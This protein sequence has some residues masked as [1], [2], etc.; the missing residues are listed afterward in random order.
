MSSTPWTDPQRNAIYARGGTL[1]VSA[2]AGSGKTAVLVE[3]VV[4]L[5]CDADNP[6]DVNRL[7][8]VTFSNAAANE[9]KQRV[10]LRLSQEIAKDPNNNYLQKQ[11]A[12]LGSASIST[13]HAF[14]LD[15]I[16]Q[17]FQNL[18]ISPDFMLLDE[19]ELDLLKNECVA[20]TLEYFY[21]SPEQGE[22]FT[23]LVEL[24]SSGRDDQRLKDTIF[25]IYDFA[26]SHPFYE[27]WL[28]KKLAMYN[29]TLAPKDTPWGQSILQHATEAL[30]YSKEQMEYALELID[31]DEKLI[32]GYQPMFLQDVRQLDALLEDC[33]Q[34]QWN[35]VVEQSRNF[36]FDRLGSVRGDCPDKDTVRGIRDK[37]KKMIGDLSSRYFNATEQEFQL[38]IV[39]LKPKITLLFDV[40][41]AFGNKLDEEKRIRKKLDFSDLEHLTIELLRDKNGEISP[42]AKEISSQFDYI[43]VDE[44]QDTN[45]VQDLIFTSISRNENNLFMVGDVKQSIYSFRM[46]MPEIFLEKKQE[47]SAFDGADF[48]ATIILDTNFRSRKEVTDSVNFI[49]SHSM[50]PEI[51]E[52]SYDKSETLKPGAAYLEQEG[53]EPEFLLYNAENYE[54]ELDYTQLEAVEIAKKIRSMLHEG[55]QVQERVGGQLTFRPARPSDFCILLRTHRN[56]AKHYIDALQQAGVPAWAESSGGFLQAREVAAVVSLLRVLDNPLLD[57]ELAAV[58]LSPLFHFTSDELAEIRLLGKGQRGSSLYL[59]LQL[60]GEQGNDKASAMLE[61]LSHFRRFAVSHSADRLLMEI[62]SKT[63]FLELVRVMPMGQS[64]HA[65]LLLLIE[66]AAH[67]HEMGYKGLGG[68]VSLLERVE[69][70]GGD[71]EPANILGDSANVVRVMS[72][73]RSKGLEFPIVIMADAAKEFN[74][75]DLRDIT[76]LHSEFGFACVRRDPET[77]AQYRTVPMGAVQLEMQ[78]TLLSE[79]MRVLYVALTRAREK[80]I[81][82][83]TIRRNF[84][85]TLENLAEPLTKTGT[86]SPFRINSARSYSDWIL[87]ALFHHPSAGEL[88]EIVGVEDLAITP[89]DTQWRITV[90]EADGILPVEDLPAVERSAQP[91]PAVVAFLEEKAAYVYPHLAQTKLPTK[92]AISEVATG[93]SAA[94]YHFTRRPRFLSETGLTPAERGTA[95]HTFMQFAN[96]QQARDNVERE[97]QRMEQQEF[98]SALEAQSLSRERISHFFHSALAD[99]IFDSDAVHRELR[100]MAEFGKRELSQ[101]YPDLDEESKI[102]LQGVADCVFI[103]NGNAIIVDYK[104]DRLATLEELS[105]RY[106]QQLALYREILADSLECPVTETIL[107]SFHLSDWV[108]TAKRFP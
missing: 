38:D 98:L 24:L 20:E 39:D 51:G 63:D 9:M 21:A 27:E 108:D 96:Y 106:Y 42:Q 76:L 13:V 6:V 10:G 58:M 4:Q 32:K 17:N 8:V 55:Y 45:E 56:K 12:L 46:A 5:I 47:Y 94:A 18:S 7:L 52:I 79:E 54:G 31:R 29:E 101:L 34:G 41:K 60:A 87:L 102:V 1:L 30:S 61:L 80:L 64:R 81:I 3:R 16:R 67:Y 78:K 91:D 71:L 49:F 97:I 40:V 37:V 104:T 86:I 73:H 95:L 85:R 19:T 69:D 65:N 93:E 59:C 26:R 14:C 28:D 83:S 57:I 62:Y 82:S 44:Y 33:K 15:L 23:E 105:Q 70:R 99:R 84:Q 22:L 36:V 68:F 66:Y 48:P 2:A 89:D 25:K 103:E 74:L 100:F 35:A 77:L 107:Y 75:T 88:R 92:L 50:S 72:I 43:L 53:V 11:Q 90:Q